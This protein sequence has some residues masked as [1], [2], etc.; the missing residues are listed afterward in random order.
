MV[1]TASVSETVP[2]K[3]NIQDISSSEDLASLKARDPFM[4]Y[5]IPSVKEATFKGCD[6]D[7]STLGNCI[8]ASSGFGDDGTVTRQTRLTF[9]YA[10]DKGM[11]EQ[12]ASASIEDNDM[13]SDLEY[14]GDAFLEQYL[15]LVAASVNG[16]PEQ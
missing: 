14:D 13:D 4:Y 7:V 16:G 8:A 5:S 9:E 3:L 10:T 2:R 1:P 12:F 6:V 11:V 15:A